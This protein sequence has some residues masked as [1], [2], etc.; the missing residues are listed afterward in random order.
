LGKVCVTFVCGS[1][2]RDFGV[3]HDVGI[4]SSDCDELGDTTRHLYYTMF[5]FLSIGIAG[6][7]K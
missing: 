7:W 5:L 4:L 6:F 2:K 1:E 3:T